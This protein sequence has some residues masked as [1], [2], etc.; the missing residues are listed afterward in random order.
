MSRFLLKETL[1]RVHFCKT[2]DKLAGESKDPLQAAA[3]AL[4]VVEAPTTSVS[5]FSHLLGVAKSLTDLYVAGTG[6]GGN[7]NQCKIRILILVGRRFDLVAKADDRGSALWPLWYQNC[8]ATEE[9]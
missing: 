6:N 2:P 5:S 3:H 7:V 8:R 4:L 9:A 1:G